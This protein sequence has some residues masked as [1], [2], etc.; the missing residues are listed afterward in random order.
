LSL[1]KAKELIRQASED[2][3]ISCFDKAVSSA[4]FAAR[5]VVELFLARRRLRLPRRDDKLANLLKRQGFE[6]AEILLLLYNWRKE[7]DY[8]PRLTDKGRAEEALKL[9]KRV[10]EALKGEM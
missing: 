1:E 8:G 10:I 6:E 4:Y 9:A 3:R 5:M 2:P 7:S